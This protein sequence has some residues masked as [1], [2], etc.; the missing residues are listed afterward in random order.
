MV[1]CMSETRLGLTAAA[2]LVS[3]RPNIAFADLD[4]AFGKTDLVE[5][6]ITYDGGNITLPDTPGHGA[7]INPEVLESL[8]SCTI[9]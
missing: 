1:G 4:S 3:A 2:H 8:E 9:T 6:G 5:G 7:D